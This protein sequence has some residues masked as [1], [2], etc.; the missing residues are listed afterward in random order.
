MFSFECDYHEGAHPRILQ[1]LIDINL[2]QLPGYGED[3]YSARAK[4]RIREACGCPEADVFFFGGGT[5]DIDGINAVAEAYEAVYDL[6][7]R[8]LEKVTEPG[9]Y[10]VNGKKVVGD[11]NPGA[12]VAGVTATPD[13]VVAPYVFVDKD[14]VERTGTLVTQTFYR[15][16]S[17]PS[18]DLGNDYDL[19]FVMG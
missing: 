1:R 15:G 3:E 9:I 2:E 11:L 17:E 5:T 6:Q 16:A 8:K 4:Q 14:G 10:I 13:K 19:F 12:N 7:G 18:A